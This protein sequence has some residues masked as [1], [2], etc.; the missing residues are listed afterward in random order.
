[1]A[2]KKAA[3]KYIK[4]SKRNR[5]RRLRYV[6]KIKEAVKTAKKAI[7]TKVED[8]KD[9]LKSAIKAIDKAVSAGIMHK[10]TAARKKSRLMRKK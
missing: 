9:L 7:G 5:Q 2:N 3:I 4:I 1:M 6:N 8:A 10:N